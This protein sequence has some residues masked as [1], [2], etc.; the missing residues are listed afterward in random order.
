MSYIGKKPAEAVSEI[1]DG[2]I[3]D[4]DVS[5]SAN[6][7][8]TKIR[9]PYYAS[10]SVL[11]DGST[12]PASSNHG[13]VVH[14]HSEGAIYYAHNSNWIKLAIDTAKQD[15]DD[16]LTSIS[17]VTPTANQMLYTTG[18]NAY[19]AT[20]LN[21]TSRALLGTA[22]IADITADQT[23]TGQNRGGI[24]ALSNNTNTFDLTNSGIATNNFSVI[25]T[26]GSPALNFTIDA[27]SVGQSG[28]IVFVN[29]DGSTSATAFSAGSTFKI[30]SADLTTLATAGTYWMS[31]I[32]ISSTQVLVTISAK[33]Y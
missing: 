8:D 18:S 15:V 30:A 2:V 10:L 14:A 3:V 29:G 4:A 13:R 28:N 12:L 17:G 20:D 32:C 31:Y 19:A 26:T 24:T 16:G 6:I 9:P 22:N 33:L 23:F 11:E 27:N 5:T 21:A 1:S 25:F 7:N